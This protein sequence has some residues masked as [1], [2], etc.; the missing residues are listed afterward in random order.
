M[1]VMKYVL[2]AKLNSSLILFEVFNYKCFRCEY[3]KVNIKL[4]II[5]YNKRGSM[6][7]IKYKEV[8]FELK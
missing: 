8:F 4:K 6:N 1:S 5:N 2:K 7:Y 3:T